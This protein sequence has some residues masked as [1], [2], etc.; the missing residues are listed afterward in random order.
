MAKR[1]TF[2]VNASVFDGSHSAN[3][4]AVYAYLSFCADKGGVCFPG[5]P[6]IGRHC[7][8][9]RNTVKK[10]LDELVRDGMIT[11]EITH[12]LSKNGRMLQ[13]A[14]RYRILSL[15]TDAA[16]LPPSNTDPLPGQNLTP[17]PSNSEGESPEK[18]NPPPSKIEGE[19]N[20][21]SKTITA[22]V[23]SVAVSPFDMRDGTDVDEIFDRLYLHLFDDQVFAQAVGQTIRRMY[24]A[25]YTKI[26]GERIENE[27]VRER[28]KL[29]TVDH[30]DYV[31]K[32]IDARGG[33]VVNGERYLAACLY[34]AP[35]DCMVKNARDLCA[36]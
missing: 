5:M 35:I 3:A 19:I 24:Y 16:R 6:A 11:S 23:P 21:N 25:P 7:G 1:K 33:E 17:H 28:L 10:A 9:T 36:L 22:D 31:E 34:H 30:I 26:D 2:Y 12:R 27:T 14:N 8:M 13:C 18:L 29:L 4:I 32:Q 20:N 15:P